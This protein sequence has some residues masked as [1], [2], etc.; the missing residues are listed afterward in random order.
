MSGAITMRKVYSFS[1]PDVTF[2]PEQIAE[3]SRQYDI[4]EMTVFDID[5]ELDDVDFGRWLRMVGC[6]EEQG[7]EA[8]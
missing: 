5:F 3:S 8:L 6:V 4:G 7:D 2:A 1:F